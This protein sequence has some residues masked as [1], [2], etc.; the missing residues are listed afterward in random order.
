M[1]GLGPSKLPTRSYVGC[2]GLGESSILVRD[3]Y[4]NVSLNGAFIN[5]LHLYITQFV[6]NH[7]CLQIRPLV[8][9]CL[10]PVHKSQSSVCGRAVI[11]II[12]TNIIIK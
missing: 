2:L 12:T 6:N 10:F 4:T 9:K 11:I 5:L 8:I 7:I 1:S 3:I